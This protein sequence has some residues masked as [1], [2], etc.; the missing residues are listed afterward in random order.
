MAKIAKK[1]ESTLSQS[2]AIQTRRLGLKLPRRTSQYITFI[3]LIAPALILRLATAAYPIAETIHLS[4]RRFR[5]Y[6]MTQEYVGLGNFRYLPD[7]FGFRGAIEFTLMF[8]I[9]STLLQLIFGIL[10]AQLLNANF[11][12]RT[13]ARAV[14]LIPWAIPTIVAAYAFRWILDDQ[15]GMVTHW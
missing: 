3:I 14:N 7:D 4:L 1:R 13:I 2:Q 15:F 5:N 11:R 8:V 9:V 12:S 6:G 10:I